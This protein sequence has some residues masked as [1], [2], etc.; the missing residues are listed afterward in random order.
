[1]S[2]SSSEFSVSESE[3][4]PD[5][6][7]GSRRDTFS[8]ELQFCFNRLDVF[9]LGTINVYDEI[10]DGNDYIDESSLSSATS[11][12]EIEAS[13]VSFESHSDE[14]SFVCRQNTQMCCGSMLMHN[15]GCDDSLGLL[16]ISS[17]SSCETQI[18]HHPPM[19]NAS[20]NP[21]HTSSNSIEAAGPSVS[22]DVHSDKEVSSIESTSI[23]VSPVDS[24]DN[25]AED[26]EPDGADS[27]CPAEPSCFKLTDESDKFGYEMG[28]AA[29]GGFSTVNEET[30][31]SNGKW[32]EDVDSLDECSLSSD[33][34]E[35]DCGVIICGSFSRR[36]PAHRLGEWS[37]NSGNNH[38][39]VK[40]GRDS[41]LDLLSI[42]SDISSTE[43]RSGAWQSG[44]DRETCACSDCRNMYAAGPSMSLEAQSDKDTPPVDTVENS[45]E[46]HNSLKKMM[47]K[48]ISSFFKKTWNALKCPSLCCC[49]CCEARVE[50]FVPLQED[51]EPD[52]EPADPKPHFVAE[53]S[54]FKPTDDFCQFD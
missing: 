53:S 44:P 13:V 54:G 11:E 1:M 21:P 8:T 7:H 47:T 39:I 10:D 36:K 19:C 5:D 38:Y 27:S 33:T 16:S 50:P 18:I 29:S 37:F 12:D 4:V 25:S 15:G 3:G 31:S 23:G 43:E 28:I 26:P 14:G 32:T 40:G 34:S 17:M 41:S 24:V 22:M 49:C 9:N 42:S 20:L 48:G 45:T 2:I 6:L 46:K 30:P 35:D 52:S 51:T